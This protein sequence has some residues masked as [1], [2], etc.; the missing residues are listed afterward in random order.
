[1]H[2]YSTRHKK[3][4][5]AAKIL[6]SLKRTLSHQAMARERAKE[7]QTNPGDTILLNFYVSSENNAIVEYMENK[8]GIMIHHRIEGPLAAMPA[9]WTHSVTDFPL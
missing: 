1:M 3:E 2:P 6:V 5:E 7:I 9:H 8:D 4:R